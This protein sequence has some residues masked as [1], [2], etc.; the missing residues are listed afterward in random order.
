MILAAKIVY[1]Q[2]TI[3]ECLYL[4]GY[5]DEELNVIPN[6]KHS[7]RTTYVVQKDQIVCKVKKYDLISQ[8]KV[9]WLGIF[10]FIALLEGDDDD[11]YQKVFEE[12]SD[13][14]PQFLEAAEERE[15]RGIFEKPLRR[16]GKRTSGELGPAQSDEERSPP[17]K[18]RAHLE[19]AE[20]LPE[21]TNIGTASDDDEE[22]QTQ[23]K[24]RAYLEEMEEP[25][26]PANLGTASDDDDDDERQPKAKKRAHFEVAEEPPEPANLGTALDDDDERHHKLRNEHILKSLRNRLNPPI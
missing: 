4:G 25:P 16:S 22:P 12:C 2:L 26:E 11:R 24:K 9:S 14:L 23:S 18:K 5:E 10:D 3:R 15:Y 7:W 21:P 20:E 19:E 17:A 6:E 13:L 1:P 8:N